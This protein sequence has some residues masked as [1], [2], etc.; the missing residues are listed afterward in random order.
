MRRFL[1]VLAVIAL[2]SAPTWADSI[3]YDVNSV[4]TITAP[5]R[6]C[7]ENIAVS[8]LW[9]GAFNINSPGGVPNEII[10]G[11]LN[12]TSSGF[13]GTFS[14]LGP[15]GNNIFYLGLFDNLTGPTDEVDL[16]YGWLFSGIAPG[17]NAPG[18]S[19]A[20]NFYACQTAACTAAYGTSW[21]GGPSFSSG[22]LIQT[23]TIVSP[24]TVP[25]GDEAI[26]LSL[27]SLGAVGLAW[28]W[29]RKE[30]SAT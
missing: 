25:D 9:N 13:L 7:V 17:D 30:S 24:V 14:P 5:C 10:A 27:G 19:L 1:I 16:N 2:C 21:E 26:F 18:D 28:G 20:P 8:F 4:T 12:V 15:Q 23:A 3:E 22:I 6:G 11:S 29:R